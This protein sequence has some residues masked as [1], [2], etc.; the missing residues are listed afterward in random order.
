MYQKF[1]SND[2]YWT[3]TARQSFVRP[4]SLS[5]ASSLDQLENNIR[6]RMQRSRRF[7][8][9]QW[10]IADEYGWFHRANPFDFD[11]G[12]ASMAHFNRWLQ[13]E[14]YASLREKQIGGPG[15]SLEP[16]GP[17]PMHLHTVFMTYSECLPTILTPLAE[18][19]CF[20]QAS[21]GALN[22]AWGTSFASFAALLDP[23]N[24][25]RFGPAPFKR[26]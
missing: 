21:L 10:N 23:I 26:P 20:S 19:T 1:L 2:T 3:P 25:P 16:H 14:R 15:G 7:R 18:R 9:S 12:P 13:S 8:P 11:I 17:L 4:V 22:T 5:S 6:P 24:A